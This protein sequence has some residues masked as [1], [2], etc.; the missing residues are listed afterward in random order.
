MD[1]IRQCIAGLLVAF[2]FGAAYVFEA[3]L[4][5]I[6]KEI[7]EE[8]SIVRLKNKELQT[9][10]ETLE[11]FEKKR[12]EKLTKRVEVVEKSLDNV[13]EY[14]QKVNL[15]QTSVSSIKNNVN[16]NHENLEQQLKKIK[17][18]QDTG[19]T[20][21]RWGRTDCPGTSILVYKGYAAGSHYLHKGGVS[22][23]ICLPE[24]P[25]WGDR[26]PTVHLAFAYGTEYESNMFG[27]NAHQQDVPCSVCQTKTGINSIM[28]PGRTVCYDG[29][30]LQ[31]KGYLGAGYHDHPS[32]T[33]YICVD[34]NIQSVPGGFENKDGKL[35]YPVVA[36]CGA[37]RCSPYIENKPLTCVVCTK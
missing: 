11:E 4:S 36:K 35:I 18:L 3:R 37:L 16:K 13:E 19:P 33:E 7:N 32:A 20:F 15:I 22:N 27:E 21:V 17:S 29:W 5:D 2:V 10:V 26:T 31:Y 30:T 23:F 34:E 1:T 25:Q 9:K 12:G 24:E 28:I 14:R 6:Y 8:L